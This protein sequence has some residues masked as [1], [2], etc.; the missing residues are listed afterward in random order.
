MTTFKQIKAHFH[1][2]LSGLYDSKEIDSFFYL[3][4]EK[5]H[6]LK[7]IDLALH[8]E[9]EIPSEEVSHWENVL[10]AL[11]QEQ[12]IQYILGETFFYD[13]R[14]YVNEFTLIPRPETEELVA[15]I[16]EE[17]KQKNIQNPTILDIGTGTGC[18]P[19]ALKKNL[20][21]S[22]IYAIDISEEALLIAQK[23]AH[24]NKTEVHFWK[25]NILETENLQK[26]FDIIVS[27]PPYVRQVE[28]QEMKTNVLVYEPHL[29][30]FVSDENPLVFYK[31]IAQ[32]AL[33]HLAPNGLLFFEINQYLGNETVQFLAK[34]GFKH[35]ELRKDMYGND[36]MIKALVD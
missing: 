9:K 11:Q 23:N 17:I 19:I 18:I 15:W 7:R 26:Q 32:L 33:H 36:R 29:A 22:S 13:L 10:K 30:L 14:L 20:S 35:I 12:P 24:N 4:L 28:K 8:P 34:L 2:Q 6:R 3:T 16:L 27:N 21:S 5:L 1:A 31:K 25:K